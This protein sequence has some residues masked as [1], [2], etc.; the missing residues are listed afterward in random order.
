MKNKYY[1]IGVFSL[2]KK[3]AYT[4]NYF[5]GNNAIFCGRLHFTVE[6]IENT[7]LFIDTHTHIY[8]YN[9]LKTLNINS[10]VTVNDLSNFPDK[11]LISF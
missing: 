9:C 8:I 10:S 6:R 4:I 3:D 2:S 1:Y 11:W 5:H 7:I